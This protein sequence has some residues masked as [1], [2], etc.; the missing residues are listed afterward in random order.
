ME[1]FEKLTLREKE[2]LSL[3]VK[4]KNNPEIANELIV[5]LHTVKAHIESIY[6]KL[7]VHNRVQAAILAVT[8]DLL[9]Q[10]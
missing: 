10:D 2:I 3:I 1:S 9:S 4:G 7:K 5:S 8:H 6:R